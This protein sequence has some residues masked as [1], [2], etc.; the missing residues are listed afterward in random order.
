MKEERKRILKM[1][2][3]GTITVEEA[4]LLIEKL[5]VEYKNK[6]NSSE[7]KPST[8]VKSD[9]F[10]EDEFVKADPKQHYSSNDSFQQVKHKVLDLV[11]Q[12]VKKIKDID[13]DLQ[14]AKGIEINHIFQDPDAQVSE[15]EFDIPYGSLQIVPWDE[16]GIKLD[17]DAKVYKVDNTDEARDVFLKSSIFSVKDGKFR[18]VSQPKILKVNA[19][20]YIPKQ[21]YENVL[22]KL[23][24]GSIK[25]KPLLSKN[26]VLKSVN[27]S[28]IVEG[29]R[30]KSLNTESTN[31]SITLDSCYVEQV[32][33]ESINGKLRANGEFNKVDF[34]CLNGSVTCEV[35]NRDV[36]SVR[37]KAGT[38]SIHLTLPEKIA[39]YGELKSNL[40]NVSVHLEAD[41]HVEKSE[42]LQKQVTFQTEKSAEEKAYVFAE[43]KTG[44][45]T[46]VEKKKEGISIEK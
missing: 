7:T 41:V 39:A 8:E 26:T 34:Q 42:V 40:G 13:F 43:T 46:V 30:G 17:C 45:I 10:T 33:S 19:V 3:N 44:S 27:G 23:F 35:N 20:A 1:V 37:L 9:P 11:D 18:F 31:G 15:V 14:W 12:A 4:L 16:K 29:L 24:N 21:E 36:N 5:E 2:E 32:E 6:T 38:G 22:A 25:T 28:I